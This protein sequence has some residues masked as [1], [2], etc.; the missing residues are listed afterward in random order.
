MKA[1]IQR[2]LQASVTVDSEVVSQIGRGICVLVGI[3]KDDGEKDVEF[4]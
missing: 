1:V 4:M 2:V 3:H